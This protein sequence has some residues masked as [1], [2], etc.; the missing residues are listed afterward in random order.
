[1]NKRIARRAAAIGAGIALMLAAAAPASADLSSS[2]E[3]LPVT[4]H[5]GAQTIE[6]IKPT[7]PAP[8]LVAQT[9]DGTGVFFIL[10]VTDTATGTVVF[11]LPDSA[12]AGFASTQ[13]LVT[14]TGIGPISG[15]EVTVL[16]FFTPAGG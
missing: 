6:L 9:A 11:S 10:R 3:A 12:L 15:R 13:D 7:G 8:I 1:M 5:C 2:P 14:C 4:L 16:G